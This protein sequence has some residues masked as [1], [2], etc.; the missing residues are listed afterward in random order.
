MIS[1]ISVIDSSALLA[2]LYNKEL[3]K[4]TQ[5]YFDNSYMSVINASEC[6]TILN[7]NGMPIKVAQNLLES[8]ISKFIP[9]EYNDVALIAETQ[10]DNAHLNLSLGD[11]ICISLGNKLGLKIITTNKTWINVKSNSEIICIG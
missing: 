9:C 3:L 7:K 1:R 5:K 8:I 10:K 6:I 4:K 11:V 2:L